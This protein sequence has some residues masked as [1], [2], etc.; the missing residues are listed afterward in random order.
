MKIAYC[1]DLHL[2]FANI[3]LKNVDN[4]DVLL[5]AGDILVADDFDRNL[6]EDPH[7]ILGPRQET[8]FRYREFL[9][10][11][12]NEFPHVVVVAGNHE[13]YHGKWNK[14]FSILNSEYGKF[15]N[16]HFLEN[17]TW[18]HEDV[19]FV[20]AT[21]WTNLNNGDPLTA[22]TLKSG[23]S[24]YRLIINEEVGYTK[25]RPSHT[26]Q[27]HYQSLQYI[28][29]K[30]EESPDNKFVIVSHHSPSFASVSPNFIGDTYMNGGYCSDLSNFILDNPQIK[31]WAHGHIHYNWDY[32][33][34]NSRILCNPRGYVGYEE[35]ANN[36]ELKW[37]EV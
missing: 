13:F 25:L 32:D 10:N 3:E 5:L 2:E 34:G 27:R 11:I 35:L 19:T 15:S 14:T 37:V 24:D 8:A 21:L 1:S 31:I 9:Q 6:P 26:S 7:Q 23:M 28:R 17:S 30:V 22:H 4:I 18:T 29:S 20:G 36:F 16:I 12:S 33:I